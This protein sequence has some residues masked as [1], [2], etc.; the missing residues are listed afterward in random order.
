M[1]AGTRC[2]MT[3]VDAWFAGLDTINPTG[4]SAR[5]IGGETSYILEYDYIWGQESGPYSASFTVDSYYSGFTYNCN[6]KD[7]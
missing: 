7:K 6:R 1:V 4:K 3:V 2:S 5:A